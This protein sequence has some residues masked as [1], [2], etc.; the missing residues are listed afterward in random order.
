VASD[1]TGGSGRVR[2]RGGGVPRGVDLD[3]EAGARV[4]VAHPLQRGR[5]IPR[6]LDDEGRVEGGHG[7]AG[8][9]ADHV[10]AFLDPAAIGG[11]RDAAEGLDEARDRGR[12][13]PGMSAGRCQA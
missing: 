4:E 5:T 9:D 1:E 3:C 2:D 8:R 12:D 11:A 13:L 10:V 7:H 6:R